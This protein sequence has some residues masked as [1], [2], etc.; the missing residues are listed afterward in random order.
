MQIVTESIPLAAAL[1]LA[2]PDAMVRTPADGRVVLVSAQAERL[3]G[4]F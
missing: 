2:A 4:A 1:L 3:Y